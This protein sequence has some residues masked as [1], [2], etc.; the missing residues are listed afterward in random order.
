MNFMAHHSFTACNNLLHMCVY[1][2]ILMD[3]I[4]KWV[5][6]GVQNNLKHNSKQ[7]MSHI[8]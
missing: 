2:Y 7:A 8:G 1:I 5:S 4:D 6:Y 3:Q